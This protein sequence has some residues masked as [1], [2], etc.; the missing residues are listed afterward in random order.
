MSRHKQ[1]PAEN[2]LLVLYFK[3]NL[4]SFKRLLF[5][6]SYGYVSEY[7][8]VHHVCAG[9]PGSQKKALDPLKCYRLGLGLRC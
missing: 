5:L 6:S 2:K 1:D 8:S 3:I 9:G 7:V 4:A